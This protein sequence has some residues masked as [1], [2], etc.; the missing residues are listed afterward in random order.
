MGPALTGTW[1]GLRFVLGPWRRRLRVYVL[2]ESEDRVVVVTIRDGPRVVGRDEL[3]PV[4]PRDG[5]S[6]SAARLVA[7]EDVAHR[8]A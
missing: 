5:A 7:P 1:E 6:D 2:V 3:R 8:A 4:A